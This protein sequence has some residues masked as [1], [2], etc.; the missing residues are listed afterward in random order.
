MKTKVKILLQIFFIGIYFFLPSENVLSQGKNKIES[1]VMVYGGT[2][3][4]VIAAVQLKKMGKSVIII[5]PDKHLGGMSSSGLGFTDVGNKSVIGGLARE[6]YH[7]IYLYYQKE[8][9]WKWQKKEDYGNAGQGTTA[10]DE[11]GK[12]MWNFEPHVAEQV[13]E[14][15]INEFNIPVYRNEFLDR[16]K[17]VI[18]Q[19][20][21]IVFIKTLS[22][23]KF[24]AKI[25]I[26]ATT[27]AI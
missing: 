14:D 9:A 3:A 11:N 18:K 27:K 15:F 8:N 7:R 24:S 22:G 13:F 20:G 17:G 12:T 10:I 25:F 26:D 6:F 5:S 16:K 23:K 4:S 2:S 19:N 21:K 1:D